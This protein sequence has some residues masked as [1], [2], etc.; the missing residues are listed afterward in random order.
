MK[1]TRG[2]YC[3]IQYCPD[4]SRLEA[5][6]IGVVLFCPDLSVLLAKVTEN[7]ERVERL[8]GA[9]DWYQHIAARLSIKDRV[10]VEAPNI[11]TLADLQHFART[12]ANQILITEPRP[13][14]V[15]VTEDDLE[16]LF[17]ELVE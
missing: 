4:L 17:R 9:R 1:P 6:N 7:C 3:L 15:G 8:F 2:Y 16:Q 14:R 5:A 12:R 13:M 11:K 10:E